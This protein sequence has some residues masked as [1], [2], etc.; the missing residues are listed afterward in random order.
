MKI[1]GMYK[2]EVLNNE[3]AK[4]GCTTVTKAEVENLLKAMKEHKVE[5]KVGDFVKVNIPRYD[6]TK[7]G[8]QFAGLGLN[9][10]GKVVHTNYNDIGVEFPEFSHALHNLDGKTTKN[11][12]GYWFDPSYLEKVS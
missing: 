3:T 8:W 6:E 12:H 2:V 9:P 5:F 7:T 4:V 10:Y 11:G 1:A